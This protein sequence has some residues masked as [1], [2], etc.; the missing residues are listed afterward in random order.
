MELTRLGQ[1]DQAKIVANQVYETTI[2]ESKKKS[3]AW[4]QLTNQQKMENFTSTMNYISTLSTAKN[5]ALAAVGKAAAISMATVDTFAAGSKALASAPPPLNFVLMGA[6]IAA[7][8]AN[9]A[10]IVGV[11]MAQGGIVNPTSGGTQAVIGEA[12]QAEAVIPLGD[13]RSKKIIKEAI[14]TD[15]AA[16]ISIQITVQGTFLEA[17]SEKWKSLVRDSIIPEI[18]RFTDISPKGPFTRRRGR[19]T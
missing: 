16:P 13:D 18:R 3:V 11:K 17:N 10:R 14:Q 6:V 15:A 4:E 2:A 12:G 5:K 1:Q 8:L 19:N 9:V 7:G